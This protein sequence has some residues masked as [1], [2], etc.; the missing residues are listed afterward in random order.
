MEERRLREGERVGRFVVLRDADGRLHAVAATAV[1]AVC[2]E[3]GA[4]VL[5][6]PGGRMIRVEQGMETVLG[7]LVCLPG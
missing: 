7:W 6:L 1:A 3:D 2:E 4:S 5:L